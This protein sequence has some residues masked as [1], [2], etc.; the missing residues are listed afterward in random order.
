LSMSS[1]EPLV[2]ETHMHTPLCRHAQGEP[3]EYAEEALRK[4]LKGITVTCHAPLPEGY[5]PNVRMYREQ[6]QEYV[7]LVAA[8]REAYAGRLDVMLGIE[9]DFMPG[10]ESWLEE[11]HA[12]DP[13]NYVIGSIHPQTPEYQQEYF[14]G[15]WKA[16]Q[17]QYFHS[18][19]EAAESG[20]YDSISHPDLVKN[21]APGEYDFEDLLETIRSSLDRIAATGLA[22]ELNTSGLLKTVPEMN[23]SPSILREMKERDIPVVVGADAHNPTRVA[24][25]YPE[26]YRLLEEAGYDEVNYFKERKRISIP[27]ANARASLSV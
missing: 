2:Y 26:A 5:S 24:A 4:G 20:L 13:L 3:S 17:R 14:H 25:D 9:S 22:M 18:L 7:D 1:A 12:R 15:D 10:L 23:P 19:A 8:T 11:L 6:W 21:L 27:I 16:F